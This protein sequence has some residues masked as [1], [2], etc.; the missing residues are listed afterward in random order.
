M[1]RIPR[2]SRNELGD[3]R[4]IKPQ[5][6]WQD[7]VKPASV[8]CLRMEWWVM[9][10]GLLLAGS[11]GTF[12]QRLTNQTRGVKQ[13]QYMV[14][15]QKSRFGMASC[16]FESAVREHR[17]VVERTYLGTSPM[18]EGFTCKMSLTQTKTKPKA[19]NFK[20]EFFKNQKMRWR[21]TQ[22]CLVSLRWFSPDPLRISWLC[23]P[24]TLV[25][26]MK[27]CH[28][29]PLCEVTGPSSTNLLLFNS[30]CFL[31]YQYR[32]YPHEKWKTQMSPAIWFYLFSVNSVE[33]TYMINFKVWHHQEG[34][35]KS[36]LWWYYFWLFCHVITLI[37]H[38]IW[39][40]V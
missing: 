38:N 33:K 31:L 32:K 9:A 25:Y 19:K 7:S 20:N 18:P 14:K 34:K 16:L 5:A 35:V 36:Y 21:W 23:C 27:P 10:D 28:I 40:S 30:H 6:W 15:G 1:I 29:L 11:Q 22:A 2:R 8:Y 17:G 37:R 13:S 26:R 12:P 3:T 4:L 39:I 24:V